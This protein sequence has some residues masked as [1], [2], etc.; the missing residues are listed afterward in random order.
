MSAVSNSATD[1]LD[2]LAADKRSSAGSTLLR[3]NDTTPSRPNGRLNVQD[4]AKLIFGVAFSL[5]NMVQ[6]LSGPLVTIFFSGLI[7]SQQC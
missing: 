6:K 5:R 3:N 4:D 2:S 7:G 1:S